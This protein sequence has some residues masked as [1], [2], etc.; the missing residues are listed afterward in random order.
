M[1]MGFSK[2]SICVLSWA[3]A[4]LLTTG[5]NK[6]VSRSSISTIDSNGATTGSVA[7]S[8]V[9]AGE[10]TLANG[11]FTATVN[12]VV[13]Y[14]GADYM[15]AIQAAINGL[16]PGRTTKEWVK[17]FA[18]G[19]SG[20][21]P[22]DQI[23]FIRIPSH[24]GVD[25][26]G[27]TFTSN[28]I[29]PYMVPI[30]SDRTTNIEVTNLSIVGDPRYGIWFRGCNGMKLSNI[31]MGLQAPVDGLGLGI[32]VDNSTGPTSDLTISGSIRITGGDNSIETAGV[33]GFSIGDVL[34]RNNAA[35]G[36]LLNTS[37]NGTVGIVTGFN[38][39]TTGS[40]LGYATFR[41]AN[42]NGP[43]VVVEKVVS[44]GSGRGV[45]SVTGS[46]GCTIKA[47][48]I[49]DTYAQGI[50]L[51]NSSNTRI[52]SGTVVRGNPNIRHNNA[53]NCVTTVNGQ[54]Y[55]AVEGSW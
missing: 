22:Q 19:N 39:S 13:R 50:L 51:Q 44:R 30:Y 29:Y 27:R 47:V 31:H 4:C 12:N 38:N 46:N 1:K 6:D 18:S 54:T 41:C 49:A 20:N 34:S 52:L 8:S 40:V 37:K 16:T 53:T 48:D 55:T 25:F 3:S 15:A 14:S 32:R 9:S 35:C 2:L 24:T 17:V 21:S 28:S 45:F 36:I 33:D 42:N 11:V 10:V 23:K 26:T 5:C 43:N 7:T